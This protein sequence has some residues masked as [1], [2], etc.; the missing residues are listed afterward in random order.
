MDRAQLQPL[1]QELLH[2]KRLSRIWLFFMDHF[3]DKE[4]FTAVGEQARDP[5]VEAVI[6]EIG[7]Q[8]FADDGAVVLLQPE[9]ERRHARQQT[10][11]SRIGYRSSLQDHPNRV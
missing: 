11:L 5:F 1:K 2:E 10:G 8:R 4:E 3:G 6:A 7:Q 9:M